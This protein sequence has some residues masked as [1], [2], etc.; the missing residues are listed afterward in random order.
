M[1]LGVYCVQDAS[2]FFLAQIQIAVAGDAERRGGK[3]IVSV[4]EVIGEGM[5]DV[6][7]K[8]KFNFAVCGGH[9]KQSW[10]RA[11]NGDD[12]EIDV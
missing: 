2:R 9:A 11:G 10:Q 6:M 4:I 3:N 12:A 8:C 5:N 7:K 1:K